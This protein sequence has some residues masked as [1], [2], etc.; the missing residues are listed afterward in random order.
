MTTTEAKAHLGNYGGLI[1]SDDI[2]GEGKAYQTVALVPGRR[3]R[4]SIW[5]N[6]CA[7][8]EVRIFAG[9]KYRSY[10]NPI[11]SNTAYVKLELYFTAEKNREDIG[12][13]LM[14]GT[15]DS[16]S[17]Q[18]NFDDFSVEDVTHLTDGSYQ[19]FSAADFYVSPGLKTE[20]DRVALE[21]TK[22]LRFDFEG[23]KGYQTFKIYYRNTTGM[24]AQAEAFIDGKSAGVVPLPA[25]GAD[26]DG[27]EGNAA[28]AW[29]YAGAGDHRFKLV[30]NSFENIEIERIEVYGGNACFEK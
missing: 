12:I 14:S 25:Q 5:I 23:M 8:R 29:L 28:I 16:F 19:K 13:K 24:P 22:G 11:T 7:D 3:Y 26:A 27:N 15:D 17:L 6:G 4:A 18:L 2:E 9:E 21:C 1:A 10:F 30:L 20:N